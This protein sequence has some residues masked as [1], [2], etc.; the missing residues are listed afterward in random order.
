MY[1]PAFATASFRHVPNRCF[2]ITDPV[3]FGSFER[4]TLHEHSLKRSNKSSGALCT[5]VSNPSTKTMM[6]SSRFV[7]RYSITPFDLSENPF[8]LVPQPKTFMG[9]L[10]SL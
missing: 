9:T 4:R 5:F 10:N 2:V 8:H 1:M 7:R 3:M 6:S